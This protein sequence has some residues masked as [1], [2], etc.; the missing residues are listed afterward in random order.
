[1][2]IVCMILRSNT[3]HTVPPYCF[4]KYFVVAL[5]NAN[6]NLSLRRLYVGN[7]FGLEI[8]ILTAKNLTNVVLSE[9]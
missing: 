5:L 3:A 2:N 4:D 8:K 1:M 7:V 9:G 6:T